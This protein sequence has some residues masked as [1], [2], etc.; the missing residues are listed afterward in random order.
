[1]ASFHVNLPFHFPLDFDGRENNEA[2]IIFGT[3]PREI[4]H[5]STICRLLKRN[6]KT[7][8]DDT[9]LLRVLQNRGCY[10]NCDMSMIVSTRASMMDL[11]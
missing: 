7:L 5:D 6:P 3:D 11:G 1:V 2:Q 8:G 9:G 10:Y 4:P